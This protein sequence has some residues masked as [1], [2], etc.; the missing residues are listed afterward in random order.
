MSDMIKIDMR[1]SAMETSLQK[2]EEA[3]TKGL[4]LI[5]TAMVDIA[6]VVS[7]VQEN[8]EQHQ[9]MH[10][11]IDH[12]RQYVEVQK[13]ELIELSTMYNSCCG[14]KVKPK[15]PVIIALEISAYT[16]FGLSY[17][18]LVILHGEELINIIFH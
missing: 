13:E 1:L 16:I 15:D 12:L 8:T 18:A 6:V 10:T 4:G 7:K 3:V 5:S 17:M 11:R 2:M 9:V 14:S